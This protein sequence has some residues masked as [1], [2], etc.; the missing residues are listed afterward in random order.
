MCILL[1]NDII[2]QLVWRDLVLNKCQSL[3]LSRTQFLVFMA[4]LGQVY[5]NVL[6]RRKVP[7][8]APPICS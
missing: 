1:I 2:L 6:G 4:S 5:L 8:A 7:H 3:E